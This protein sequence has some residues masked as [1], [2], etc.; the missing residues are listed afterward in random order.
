MEELLKQIL[1]KLEQMEAENESFRK[2]VTERF[3]YV[4]EQFTQ[5]R[6]ELNDVKRVVRMSAAD[7]LENQAE[8]VARHNLHEGK[9]RSLEETT[10]RIDKSVLQL[11][12]RVEKL[13]K[14][15]D[16]K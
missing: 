10:F 2:E 7:I 4:D 6:Q 14:S 12:Q 11:K 16:G 15:I 1:G 9:I 5:M 3:D 8:E 13:E